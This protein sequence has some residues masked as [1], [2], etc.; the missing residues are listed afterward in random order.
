MRA[1]ETTFGQRLR[2]LRLQRGLSQE[3]L[4]ERAGLTS[5]AV[6][7]LEGGGR[8]RPYPRTVEVLAE[9]L[10]LAGQERAAFGELVGGAADQAGRPGTGRPTLSAPL[11]P[12]WLTS[13]VGREVEVESIRTLLGPAGSAV[14]LLT[15]VGPGGVGKTRLAVAAAEALA[16]AY[17][18]GV[19]F[20]D[21]APLRD[22]RLV[23][24]AIARALELREGGG[25]SARELLL[26]QL[27]D[28]RVLLVLDNLEHLPAAAPLLAE[29]LG[30]CPA[31]VLS[32]AAL[33]V[34][35]EHRFAVAPLATPPPPA[36]GTMPESAAM[37]AITTSPAV[38]LFVARARAVAAEFVLSE[39]NAAAVAGMCRRLDGIPLAIELAA[40]RVTLLSP[41]ALLRRLERR[42]GVLT[43]G[44]PDLPERQ[45]TLRATLA[46]SHD[47]LQPATQALFRRLAVFAGG[48]TL[49][50]AEAVCADA[51]LPAE[52]VLGQ[53]QVLVDS[54]LVRRLEDAG[55]E[56]RFG[57]LETVREYALEQLE[58]AGEAEELGRRHAAY[59]LALCE[60]AE[61]HLMSAEQAV[62]LDRLDAEL[63][64]LRAALAWAPGSGQLELG[65]E[66]AVALVRFWHERGHGREGLEWLASL[67]RGLAEF[68]TPAHL[69]ALHARALGT[70]S[71]ITYVQGDHRAAGPLA[72]QCLARWRQLGQVGNSPVALN[73]LA[74]VAGYEGD[75]PRQEALFRQSLALYRAE[76]DSRDAAW[77]LTWLGTVR[78]SADD[79]DGA[80]TLLA[81]GL[82]VFEE[83]GDSGG[84][85]LALQ[86][87]GNVAAARQDY[88]RAQ[89]LLERSLGVYREALHAPAGVA[90]VLGDL[91]GLAACR[92]ELGRAQAL[93]EESVGLFREVDEPRGLAAEL[94]LLGRLAALGGDDAAAEAAYSECLRL[95]RSLAKVDLVL[96]LEWL[97]EVRARVAARHSR[98]DQLA[99]AARLCG[100]AA[101]LRDRL[102]A[103]AARSWAIPL[104]PPHHDAYAHQVA[105]TRTA[106]GNEVFETAWRE[107]RAM[108]PEQAVADALAQAGV[109]G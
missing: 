63:D 45:Q 72:E 14:R 74:F 65:L 36:D 68:D 25:H 12:I 28:R 9:A 94:G 66:L 106:L 21:L 35:G 85:A 73:T 5:R 93:C 46:W 40:A 87:L 83:R 3:A 26:E 48:W 77:V 58:I 7:A 19:A 42:L 57:L 64:N 96:I 84:I 27:R 104:A 31:L 51:E 33:R 102:G 88:E 81:E 49:E 16:P 56:P 59:F 23:P 76:G 103:A 2:R 53:L 71:W 24:A 18:D 44:A 95:S 60:R 89:A 99:Q 69:A 10:E 1:P 75:V 8:R 98:P 34:Q 37:E 20:V 86:H 54:S 39:R 29:L 107:G 32:R 101:G 52:A 91:A 67:T 92:G 13:F 47:L 82:A 109:P 17:P 62:W 15:L 22:A 4:A 41:E 100:A 79:L 105:A 97:A 43:G 6:A 30:P 70:T 55:G 11:L 38:Q 50:A 90:Y 108:T 78:I 80:E 61:R